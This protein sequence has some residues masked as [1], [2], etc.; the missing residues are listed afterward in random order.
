MGLGVVS[1]SSRDALNES[2]SIRDSVIHSLR[3]LHCVLE[4][5]RG[6]DATAIDAEQMRVAALEADSMLFFARDLWLEAESLRFFRKRCV[7]LRNK[8]LFRI[9]SLANGDRAPDRARSAV[10]LGKEVNRYR[11][12]FGFELARLAT[13]V[14]EDRTPFAAFIRPDALQIAADI[15]ANFGRGVGD[16]RPVLSPHLCLL[17]RRLAVGLRCSRGQRVH[18]VETLAVMFETDWRVL[19]YPTISSKTSRRVGLWWE[20]NGSD[21]ERL[22]H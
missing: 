21:Y 17:S 6:L 15:R 22:M 18:L 11:D 9:G 2:E 5:S 7:T 13:C 16:E 10:A 20:L 12:R 1:A 4:K 3:S 14:R 19:G 8:A